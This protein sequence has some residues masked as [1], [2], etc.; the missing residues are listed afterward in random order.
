M[1]KNSLYH[2]IQIALSSHDAIPGTVSFSKKT[3]S[4]GKNYFM[5]ELPMESKISFDPYTLLN[6]HISVYE[7]PINVMDLKSQ[8]HYTAYFADNFGKEYRLHIYY[9]ANDNM[10]ARPFF[11]EQV[12]NN[13]FQPAHCEENEEAFK[14]LA[15][16]SI[17]TLVGFFRE[18]QDQQ[19]AKYQAAYDEIEKKADYFS[20]FLPAK[21]GQYMQVLD[22]LIDKIDQIIE[23]SIADRILLGKKNF[24]TSLKLSVDMMAT[25]QNTANK[26]SSNLSKKSENNNQIKLPVLKNNSKVFVI[27]TESLTGILKD[28]TTR[29]E[30]AKQFKDEE[31]LGMLT[32]LF[33]ELKEN[34]LALVCDAIKG[35][36]TEIKHL[37]VIKSNIETSAKKILQQYLMLGLYEKVTQHKIFH[38]TISSEDTTK[39][40][41]FLNKPGLLDLLLKNNIVT[42]HYKN[43][44]INN[45]NYRSLVDYCFKKSQVDCL[46]VL[47]K[48]GA[49]LMEIDDSNG[50]P[51]AATLIMDSNHPLYQALKDNETHTLKNHHFYKQL[52]QV[53]AVLSSH[54]DCSKE[55]KK[56]L[57][58]L[59]EKNKMN[60][61]FLHLNSL[62]KTESFNQPYVAEIMNTLDEELIQQ[63]NSDSELLALQYKATHKM[64][65]LIEKLSIKDR[66]KIKD[67]MPDVME[68]LNTTLRAIQSLDLRP[69]FEEIKDG[70][71]KRQLTELSIIDLYE[72]L[73]PIQQRNKSKQKPSRQDVKREKE[74]IET[75]N[76]LSGFLQESLDFVLSI[77]ELKNMIDSIFAHF[78]SILEL[79]QE[80]ILIVLDEADLA[81]REFKF[82]LVN[83]G[84]LIVAPRRIIPPQEVTLFLKKLKEIS[85]GLI[86]NPFKAMSL[87]DELL[88]ALESEK[89]S[90]IY[91]YGNL[92][93][94]MSKEE[95]KLSI[96]NS[97]SSTFFASSLEEKIESKELNQPDFLKK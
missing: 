48:Q 18:T 49:S 87:A 36:L 5:F 79:P 4:L 22:Q 73:I 56:V 78:S 29:F 26:S 52:N 25:H 51:Y 94:D 28:L 41:L 32:T 64:K 86:S 40:A 69:T 60:M 93:P 27:K 65:L 20:K 84:E 46:S 96:Y 59:I 10:V 42:I 1:S 82:T 92:Q 7:G 15:T 2:L 88:N 58:Q 30:Q 35:T 81:T 61:E 89:S 9:D 39:L 72:E 70:I 13:D 31:Q 3:H 80:K 57:L 47:I 11:S 71:I 6:H 62:V 91:L 54:V 34:E 53:L 68:K 37:N 95:K 76:K 43:F 21:K 38:H 63:L 97:T 14:I 8:Y 66:K 44:R 90:K 17:Q 74:I 23:C 67:E 77:T 19:I 24:L 33:A 45:E 85:S 12:A 55:N 16:R 83:A 50:L 75:I